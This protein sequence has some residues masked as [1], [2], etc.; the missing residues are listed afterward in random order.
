[1]Q[2]WFGA[3]IA[4]LGLQRIAELLYARN[5]ARHLIARGA[6]VVRPDGYALLVVVH[7]AFFAAVVAEWLWAPWAGGAAL[8][9]G[10]ILFLAG[11]GLRLASMVALGWRWNTR[12]FVVPGAPLVRRGPYR[13]LRHPIY[14]GVVLELAG[15]ALLDSLYATA[16]CITILNIVALRLRIRIEQEALS[17]A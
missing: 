4:L 2:A 7:V 13:F 11:E 16:A 5:T 12:V 14:V 9:P 15:F 10:A 1:M 8:I 17:K 6:V 3:A